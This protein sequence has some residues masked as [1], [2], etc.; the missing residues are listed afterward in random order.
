MVPSLI[1]AGGSLLGGLFGKKKDKVITAGDNIHSSAEAARSAGEK[2]GFNPLTLLGLGGQGQVFSGGVNYM[3]AGIAD[4]AQALA[5]GMIRK[6]EKTDE[7]AKL[8]TQNED[9]RRKLQNNELRPKVGGIYSGL[10]NI[11]P[12]SD[13]VPEFDRMGASPL[14]GDLYKEPEDTMTAVQAA[15][16]QDVPAFRFFGKDFFGSGA[17]SSG[18]QI[19]DGIGEGPASWFMTLPIVPDAFANEGYKSLGNQFRLKT[20]PDG[21]VGLPVSDEDFG[22]YGDKVRPK[23]RPLSNREILEKSSKGFLRW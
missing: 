12:K 21:K 2:Y 9:L 15:T 18:Q 17:F 4:A 10:N 7:A 6:V 22:K 5:G 16:S 13:D 23:K 3:G 8:R 14:A 1:A 11:K 20:G 19:E